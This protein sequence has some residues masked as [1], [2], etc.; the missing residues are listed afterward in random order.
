M[1]PGNEARHIYI[2]VTVESSLASFPGSFEKL[3]PGNEAKSKSSH[4]EP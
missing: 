2:L 1:W 3:K 4:I